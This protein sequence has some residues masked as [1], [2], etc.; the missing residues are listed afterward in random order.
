MDEVFVGWRAQSVSDRDL[1]GR[2]AVITGASRGLGAGLA[3]EFLARGMHLGLCS[4]SVPALDSGDRVLAERV[5]VRNADAVAAFAGRVAERFGEIDVWINNAG[6]LAPIGPMR[7]LDVE[8]FREH[9]DTNLVG[10]FIGSRTFVR[11]RRQ[12]GGGG[13]LINVS[14]GAAWSA[15]EGWTPYCASKAGVERF[16]Q[17]VQAEEAETGLRAYAVAPGVVDTAMQEAI[18]AC[19]A[20]SFPSVDRFLEMKEDDSFNTPRFVAQHM[21]RIAFDPEN[22]DPEV[23]QRLPD[24]RP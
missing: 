8:D 24:E 1:A 14:S 20:Q 12:R 5:D 11:H 13:V 9:V 17:C 23:A 21:L 16:T 15:Y 2:T 19:D 18:R 22:V 6:V 7:D 10:V 3:D 4:R